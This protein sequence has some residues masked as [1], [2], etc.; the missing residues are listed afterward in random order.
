MI[1]NTKINEELVNKIVK[2][3]ELGCDI[4]NFCLM[5]RINTQKFKKI[6][7]KSP[8]GYYGGRY[9]KEKSINCLQILINYVKNNKEEF[10]TQFKII[11]L[12][13]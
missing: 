9:S 3:I 8:S 5:F 2:R 4:K 11:E 12:F 6:T 13:R 7:G 1:T 10:E